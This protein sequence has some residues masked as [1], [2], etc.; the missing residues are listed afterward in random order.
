MTN[1]EPGLQPVAAAL[2]IAPMPA[3]SSTEFLPTPEGSQSGTGVV[4]APAEPEGTLSDPPATDADAGT[5]EPTDDADGTSARADLATRSA[6]AP[7]S[8]PKPTAKKGK[9]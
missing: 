1:E 9:K 4:E 5:P 6:R 7:A 2:G 3:E 8:K